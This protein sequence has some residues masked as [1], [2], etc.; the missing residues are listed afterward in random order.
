MVS[1]LSQEVLHLFTN[2]FILFESMNIYELFHFFGCLSS[3]I[4]GGLYA[5]CFRFFLPEIKGDG[6]T[7]INCELDGLFVLATQR[8][9]VRWVSTRLGFKH[10]QGYEL[11][12]GLALLKVEVE[13]KQTKQSMQFVWNIWLELSRQCEKRT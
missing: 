4:R 2:I 3:L 9:I 8:T 5:G 12:G 10:S 13:L 11:V 7:P 6:L 1:D